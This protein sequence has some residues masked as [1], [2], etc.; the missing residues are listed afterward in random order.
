MGSVLLNLLNFLHL[1][2]RISYII[3][4]FIQI[5]IVISKQRSYERDE[6]MKANVLLQHLESADKPTGDLKACNTA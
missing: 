2:G 5:N 6:L 4:K 3:N 1:S